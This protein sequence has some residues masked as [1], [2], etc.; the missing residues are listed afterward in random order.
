[1]GWT[2]VIYTN[3]ITNGIFKVL[4]TTNSKRNKLE[5]VAGQINLWVLNEP[6]MGVNGK[7]FSLLHL[8]TKD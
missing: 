4:T 7:S 2:K 3:K 5:M 1:M 6:F 8:T